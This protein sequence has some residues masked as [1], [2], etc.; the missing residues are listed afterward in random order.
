MGIKGAAS[1]GST[2][3]T[4]PSSDG[5]NGQVLK[6]NGSG[7]LSWATSSG[8]TSVSGLTDALVED[9]SMYLGNDPSSTTSTAEY[10]IC[11]DV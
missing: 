8:A 9:N 1:A 7:T 4:L 6:T 11:I 2:T 3:Y 10:N 5:S